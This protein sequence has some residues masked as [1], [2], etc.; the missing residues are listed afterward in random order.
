MKDIYA[1]LERIEERGKRIARKGGNNSD[2]QTFASGKKEAGEGN[3]G[4]I[5]ERKPFGVAQNNPESGERNPY[6]KDIYADLENIEQ[7]GKRKKSGG[8][9]FFRRKG[10]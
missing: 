3:G 4:E 7:R 10:Q 2:S 5:R 1:D 8:R 9:F 6:R